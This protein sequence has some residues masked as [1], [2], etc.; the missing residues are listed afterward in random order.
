MSSTIFTRR[1]YCAIAEV[2][3][4]AGYLERDARVRLVSDFSV[5]FASDNERFKPDTFRAAAYT[6]VKLGEVRDV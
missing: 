3:R 2:L 1:H 4:E 5:L 6:G